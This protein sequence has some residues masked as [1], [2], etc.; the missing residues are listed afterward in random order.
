MTYEELMAKRASES[1]QGPGAPTTP[2]SV[3]PSPA[4]DRDLSKL[5]DD[6]RL[7]L[8]QP[9]PD[10]A[11]LTP[12][13]RMQ[14]LEAYRKIRCDCGINLTFLELQHI[15]RLLSDTRAETLRQARSSAASAKKA[16]GA[17]SSGPAPTLDSLL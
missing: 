13:E 9:L 5:P 2:A 6:L 10:T 4:P 14:R 16:S 7:F 12:M 17:T 8:A 15:T 11:A 1:A 3:P